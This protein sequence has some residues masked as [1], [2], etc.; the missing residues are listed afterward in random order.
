MNR[1]FIHF[2]LDE[3]VNVLIADLV[4]AKGFDVTTARDAGQLRASD[5]EVFP[6]INHNNSKFK[7]HKVRSGFGFKESI[8]CLI[9][10]K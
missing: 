6:M 7:I 9:W 3:D 10:Y 5:K 8:C 4:R 2:Y 1:L